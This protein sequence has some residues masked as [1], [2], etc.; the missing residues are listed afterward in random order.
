MSW[1]VYLSQKLFCNSYS[2]SEKVYVFYGYL[3]DLLTTAFEKK[4]A[5]ISCFRV[6]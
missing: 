5:C 1:G 3:Y 2:S 6:S 4:N